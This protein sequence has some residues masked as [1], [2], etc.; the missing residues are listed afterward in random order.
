MC[1][2]GVGGVVCVCV[3]RGGTAQIELDAVAQAWKETQ[4]LKRAEQEV[5]GLGWV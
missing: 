3:G 1:V 5:G 4:T 2:C